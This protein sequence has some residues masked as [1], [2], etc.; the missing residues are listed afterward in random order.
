MTTATLRE[1]RIIVTPDQVDAKAVMDIPGARRVSAAPMQCRMECTL[2]NIRA[3]RALAARMDATLDDA[4]AQMERVERWVERE[5]RNEEPVPLKPLPVK[6]GIQLYKHQVRAYNMGLVLQTSAMFMD[7]GTGKT[8][9]MICVAGRRYLDGK[10]KRLLV[11]APTSVCAV[12]PG[13]L[14]KFAAFPHRV[15]LLLGDR[16]K[17]VRELKGLCAPMPRGVVEP[18]RVAVIN[19]ESTWR[20][21]K[22]LIDYAPDMIICDESQRIKGHATSQSKAMHRIGK[23]ARYRVILSGT[24]MQNDPR[25]FWSQYQF[26]NPTVFAQTFYAFQRRYT[27]MGGP[28]NHMML[29]T[30]NLDELTRKVHSIAY[31][32]TKAECL[33]LPEKMYED[34]IVALPEESMRL[35]KQIRRESFL[36]LEQSEITA[37]NVLV[38]LLRLQQL[39]GGF[40]TDDAGVKKAINTAKLDALRDILEDYV[41]EGGGKLVIFARFIAEVEA[42]TELVERMR[43]GHV[44]ISGSVATGRRGELVSRFQTDRATQVFIGQIDATAEGITLTAADT[45]VYYS[46]NWNLAKYQQSQDRIHRIGQANRCTYLHLVVPG[47][48]DEQIMGALHRKEDLARSITDNWKDYFKED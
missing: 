43:I 18:L 23:E 11:V 17:R 5:K 34:R 3:L 45:V 28:G 39:T 47:T 33:D 7:M 22:E 20:L 14:D 32:V 36:Q 9:T 48:I 44:V 25:D 31:R 19:Y 38:R 15:A 42:I 41:Q 37:S 27:I 46:V 8:I 10:V 12:W 6:D 21:E 16:A 30:R 24:P 1:G 29:G 26:L 13:E 35:Y 40:L 2:D 4:Q